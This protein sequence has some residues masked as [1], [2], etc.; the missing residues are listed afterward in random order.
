M[1]LSLFYLMQVWINDEKNSSS[2]VNDN[3]NDYDE[4]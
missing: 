1:Q 3:E 2:D 4:L